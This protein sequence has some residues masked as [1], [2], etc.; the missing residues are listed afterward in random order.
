[1]SE[2]VAYAHT[3]AAWAEAF[4]IFAMYVPSSL[5]D[6][7]TD[8][9]IVFAGPAPE[10]MRDKDRARLVELGWKES[11]EGGWSHYV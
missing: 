10:T 8:H 4:T 11:R 7:A 3:Y 6:V 1:M 5:G 2:P 9:D